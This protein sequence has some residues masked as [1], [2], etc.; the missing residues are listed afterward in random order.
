MNPKR[1]LALALFVLSLATLPV[2][3]DENA[4]GSVTAVPGVAAAAPPAAAPQ[5]LVFKYPCTI[6]Y[7]DGAPLPDRVLDRTCDY[8]HASVKGGADYFNALPTL[9]AQKAFL[10]DTTGTA[11]DIYDAYV[12]KLA[13]A[14]AA[15]D[16]SK[17]NRKLT[18]AARI[19]KLN[20][21]SSGL[22]KGVFEAAKPFL[23]PA[24]EESNY[25]DPAPGSWP[26]P[27][28]QYLSPAYPRFGELYQ[29]VH[30]EQEKII[31]RKS[32]EVE[33]KIQAS[34]LKKT[35]EVLSAPGANQAAEL[36]K[37]FDGIMNAPG[38]AH[39]PDA[40]LAPGAEHGLKAEP[41]PSAAAVPDAIPLPVSDLQAGA[42]PIPKD[43]EARGERNYFARGT[44]A[45]AQRLRD[46]ARITV[47][48]AFGQSQTIG[49]PYGK[50]PFIITQKGPSCAVAAQYEAMLTRGEQV[51]IAKLAR[52][53][54]DK[55]YYVDYPNAAG[56]RVGGTSD[57]K[58]N[59]LLKDHKVKSALI[60]NATPDQLD[61][62]IRGSGDAIVAVRTKLFWND[63]R[64]G[65][66]EGHAVYVTGEEVG[67][68][69]K[70]LG[71]YFN[72]TGTGEAA[73]FVSADVFL[74]AWKKRLVVLGPAE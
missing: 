14:I 28:G 70:V 61:R 34:P 58:L 59:A 69:G 35:G 8:I 54:R 17:I 2:R 32:A 48:H 24:A 63:P 5:K 67:K 49:D 37:V 9:A 71:Y 21:M 20:E 64:L 56:G 53:G 65:D 57:D 46:D 52:E 25:I 55:G 16:P 47:W 43:E 27:W 73:R 41:P 22:S 60:R 30:G 36:A 12:T 11:Q 23:W 68:D 51:D 42:P 74:R 26:K 38:T 50:A 33:K 18:G 1:T 15:N 10:E 4:S 7:A 6:A 45:G 39:A 19:A 31:D 29:L 62:A 66:N 44:E 3:A 40:V 13:A 72:D